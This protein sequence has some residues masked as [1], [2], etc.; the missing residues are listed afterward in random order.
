MKNPVAFPHVSL[1]AHVMLALG[2]FGLLLVSP[3][4]SGARVVEKIVVVVDGEPFTYWD[5]RKFAKAK[6][7]RTP[8]LQ[9]LTSGQVSKEMLEEFITEQLIR[10]EVKRM[11]IH[12]SDRDIDNYIQTVMQRSNLT[13]ADLMA[14]LQRDGVTMAQYR[15]Q[16]RSQLE[17]GELIER[18]VKNKVHI[19]KEDLERYYKANSKEFKTAAKIHLRHILLVVPEGATKEQEDAVRARIVELRKQALAGVSF[20]KLAR[21]YSQGAGAQDG[22][23]I[24]WVDRGALLDPLGN[25]AF[26]LSV[27]EVSE[28]VRT[29]M[30]YHLVKLEGRKDSDAEAFN[31]VSQEIR[32]ELY[33]KA[34]QERF[35]TWLKTDLRE[36]HRVEVKLAGYVFKAQKPKENTVK[37]LMAAADAEPAEKEKTFLDY[38]NP[39]TYIVKEKPVEDGK[40]GDM[41]DRKVVSVFGAPLFTTEA[42]DDVDVPLDKPFSDEGGSA[43]TADSTQKSDS[44]GDSSDSG[45]ANSSDSSGVL[46]KLWPF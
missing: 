42:G 17:R 28:P 30:G 41:S 10:A 16:V 39:L 46:S 45:G 40:L 7:G 36:K 4:T 20:A 26:K 18:N 3:V 35:S 25:V 24:G 5:F 29:S 38:I 37:R 21:E 44:S 27:G 43:A 23:D 6:L 33:E 34:L 15:D 31:Q 14:A 12:V 32:K 19:T 9:E 11:G 8:S 22:G 2:C 1:V 13:S